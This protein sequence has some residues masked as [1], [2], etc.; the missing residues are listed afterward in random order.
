MIAIVVSLYTDTLVTSFQFFFLIA[1]FWMNE[2]YLQQLCQF[3]LARHPLS[4]CL[5]ISRY[6]YYCCLLGILV[7]MFS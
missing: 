7:L 3:F 1:L 4:T 5:W 2:L 6:S